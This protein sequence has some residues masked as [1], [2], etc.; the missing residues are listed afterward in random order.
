MISREFHHLY[1]RGGLF[2]AWFNI[3]HKLPIPLSPLSYSPPFLL[4]HK[5]TNLFLPLFSSP[6][7]L[8]LLPALTL[9]N[10]QTDPFPTTNHQTTIT[11]CPVS[12]TT[13]RACPTVT[14]T[15]GIIEC[16]LNICLQADCIRLVTATVGCPDGGCCPTTIPTVT[17]GPTCPGCI[18]GCATSVTTVTEC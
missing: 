2:S 15:S 11:Q 3:I 6:F 18:Q 14:T 7:S 12:T 5:Q 1:R 8:L 16:P 13:T 4:S 10:P 17:V 9:S